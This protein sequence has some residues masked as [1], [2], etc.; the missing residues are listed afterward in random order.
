MTTQQRIKQMHPETRATRTLDRPHHGCGS[1]NGILIAGVSYRRPREDGMEVAPF[2]KVS[3]ASA[4]CC[5]SERS[6]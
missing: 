3:Q 4:S 2:S 1:V 6:R 5:S